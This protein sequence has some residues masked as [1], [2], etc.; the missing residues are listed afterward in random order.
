MTRRTMVL[1]PKLFDEDPHGPWPARGA[2][3]TCAK[4]G[5]KKFTGVVT[6]VWMA[7]NCIVIN[8][9]TPEGY[10]EQIFRELGDTCTE[11]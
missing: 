10:K 11:V 2:H 3:V 8:V 5:G 4:K 6:L 7:M 9:A 1:D